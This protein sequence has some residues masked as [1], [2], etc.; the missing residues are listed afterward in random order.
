MLA[1]PPTYTGM[2]VGVKN[3]A[4]DASTSVFR[5]KVLLSNPDVC[6]PRTVTRGSPGVWHRRAGTGLSAS[7]QAMETAVTA[8]G[9][10]AAPFILSS[11]A[12]GSRSQPSAARI[13]A[14]QDVAPRFMRQGPTGDRGGRAVARALHPVG[15]SLR[16]SHQWLTAMADR[17]STRLNS[18]H[19]VISYAV[20]C[21]KKK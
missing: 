3:R 20:F 8:A 18:S 15:E 5:A 11:V 17:K 12:R 1:P 13:V 21:L 10:H 16:V 7:R 14:L 2:S 4:V 19:L 6:S 9:T